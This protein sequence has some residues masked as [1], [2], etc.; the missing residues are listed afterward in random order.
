MQVSV[1]VLPY[2]LF[3]NLGGLGGTKRRKTVRIAM[4]V[5]FGRLGVGKGEELSQRESNVCG[6]GKLEVPDSE[7]LRS[8]TGRGKEYTDFRWR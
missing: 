7:A 8:G 6:E 3:S 4:A 2:S 5:R 1:K